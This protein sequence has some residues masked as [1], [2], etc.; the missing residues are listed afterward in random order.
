MGARSRKSI[1][2]KGCPGFEVHPQ[3][4]YLGRCKFCMRNKAEHDGWK[5]MPERTDTSQVNFLRVNAQRENETAEQYHNR[6]SVWKPQGPRPGGAKGKVL[7]SPRSSA[8]LP[9]AAAGAANA[10]ST[11][12]EEHSR[13]ASLVLENAHVKTATKANDSKA[14]K[15]NREDHHAAVQRIQ[16]ATVKVVKDSHSSDGGSVTS[17]TSRRSASRKK[18]WTHKRLPTSDLVGKL[19]ANGL[20]GGI[21]P[22]TGEDENGNSSIDMYASAAEQQRHIEHTRKNSRRKSGGGRASRTQPQHQPAV[23]RKESS[24]SSGS[25]EEEEEDEGDRKQSMMSPEEMELLWES[26]RS[27]TQAELLRQGTGFTLPRAKKNNG[28]NSSSSTGSREQLRKEGALTGSESH[29]AQVSKLQQI[30][31]NTEDSYYQRLYQSGGKGGARP[32]GAAGL[33]ADEREMGSMGMSKAKSARL[34]AVQASFFPDEE[35][36]R[37]LDKIKSRSEV[38]ALRT[39]ASAPV[40]RSVSGGAGGHRRGPSHR[41]RKS[42]SGGSGGRWNGSGGVSK[43]EASKRNVRKNKSRGGGTLKAMK[44]GAQGGGSLV[45]TAS[46]FVAMGVVMSAGSLKRSPSRGRSQSR[47]SR[48]PTNSPRTK[49]AKNPKF[50]SMKRGRSK[51]RGNGTGGPPMEYGKTPTSAENPM[52]LAA[53]EVGTN[54]RQAANPLFATAK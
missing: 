15:A 49:S 6:M 27:P 52:F 42:G 25:D 17:S 11:N 16:Q 10:S 33:D 46:G 2:A 29:M 39:V 36:Q 41:L 54:P 3:F 31:H 47:K 43:S 20:S 35:D 26:M 21:D 23:E 34:L 45:R 8:A 53:K 14:K 50:D 48:S 19:V 22:A 12:L 7:P 1:S 9:A 4:I 5:T 24:S 38:R 30:S 51:T 13:Q 37:Q 18:S 40:R 44:K 32:V 28:S